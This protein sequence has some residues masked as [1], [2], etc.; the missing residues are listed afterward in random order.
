MENPSSTIPPNPLTETP[1][2]APQPQPTQKAKSLSKILVALLLV[3]LIVGAS[4][5]FA[6]TYVVL[7]G[8]IDTLQSQIT[9]QSAAIMFLI[10]TPHYFVGDNVSLSALYSTLS[11]L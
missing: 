4:I 9:G 8:R 2:P 6:V 3:G 11:H 10:Q 5:G 7:N 1:T